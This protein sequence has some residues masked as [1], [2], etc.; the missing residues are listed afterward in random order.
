MADMF[1]VQRD[2]GRIEQKLDSLIE[3]IRD[4]AKRVDDLEARTSK[5]E[6]RQAYWTGGGTV[7]GMIIGLFIKSKTGI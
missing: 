5:L 3:S 2:L 7:A 4:R 6:W 1:A